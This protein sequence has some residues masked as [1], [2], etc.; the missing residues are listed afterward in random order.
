MRRDRGRAGVRVR[1]QP[2]GARFPRLRRVTIRYGEPLDFARY[3]GLGSSGLIRRAVTDEIMDAIAGLSEQ[4]YVDT[5][6]R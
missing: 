6:H 1:V 3:E 5:Y 4:E 2:V